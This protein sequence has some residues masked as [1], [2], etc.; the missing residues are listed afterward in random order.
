VLRRIFQLEGHG[1]TPRREVLAGL[2]TFASLASL[3][4]VLPAIL[5]AAGMDRPAL[6][7]AVAVSSALMTVVMACATNYPI[8][9]GTGAGI[10]AFFAYNVC[11]TLGIPWPAAL[12]LV[13]YSGVLFL[14]LS[15][16]GIRQKLVEAIPQELKLAIPCGIGLFITLI[17][18]KNGGLVKG[19]PATFVTLG[20]LSSPESLLVLGGI[21]LTGVLIG[22]KVPGAILLSVLGIAAIGLAVPQ[23]SGGRMVTLLP[24]S[25][26]GW[27]ASLRPVLLR[28][29]LR[30]LWSHLGSGIAVILAIL[31]IDLFDNMGTLLGVCSRAGL[32]DERGQLPKL[33]QAFMA[34]ACAAMAAACI[35]SST[36][37]SCIESATGV[38]AGGRTGL[39]ALTAAGALI[40]ALFLSPILLAIPAAA[41]A[42]ALIVMGA[43]M[44]QGISELDLADLSRAIPAFLTM[45]MMPFS[46]SILEGIGFGLITHVGIAVGTGRAREVPGLTYLLSGLFLLHYVYR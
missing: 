41:T 6:V 44:L 27:P 19:S 15:V 7:T 28:L 13:F 46:F 17:G 34:D 30:Y 9:M 23:A 36:V 35:G 33:R 39:T 2:T 16:S 14:L 5:S 10:A 11:G 20:D 42:P 22:R 24:S 21:V 45:V 29:D 32:L 8:V 18:L 25:V 26:L 37:T 31:F 40:L 43:F 38:A 1:T 12:G 3:L 4:V